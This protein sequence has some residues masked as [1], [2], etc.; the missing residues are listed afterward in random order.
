[1]YQVSE[2]EVCKKVDFRKTTHTSLE[3]ETFIAQ[4]A[5]DYGLGPSVKCVFEDSIVMEKMDGTLRELLYDNKVTESDLVRVFQTL[6]ALHRIGIWHNDLHAANVMYRDGLIRVF[7]M[8]DF[9]KSW[10]YGEPIPIEAQMLDVQRLLGEVV[11][12][13]PNLKSI[14]DELFHQAFG[15][16]PPLINI[17]NDVLASILKDVPPLDLSWITE[18]IRRT[19]NIAPGAVF[20]IDSVLN[21][22]FGSVTSK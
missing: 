14:A 13:Q 21:A 18:Y 20:Y 8:I 19:E 11:R 16:R 6:Q 17:T 15:D 2:N 12:C 10:Y 3:L 22:R 7:K 5:S 9:G 1:M 4:Y